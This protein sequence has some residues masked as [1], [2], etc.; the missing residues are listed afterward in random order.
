[1]KYGMGTTNQYY[2]WNEKNN[3]QGM[4]VTLIFL[5]GIFLLESCEYSFD[6]D[7]GK[8]YY[9]NAVNSPVSMTICY[10]D[11]SGCESILPYTIYKVYWNTNLIIALR[12][13]SDGI[14]QSSIK[15]NIVEHFIINKDLQ[16]NHPYKKMGPFN[17][18]QLDSILYKYKIDLTKMEMKEFN[19][20]D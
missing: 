11:E 6:K 16:S 18:I 8:G 10:G 20:L 14:H 2:I 13:P 17:S 19:Y 5:V 15:K 1:M 12:H 7:I 9:I 3:I 4:R